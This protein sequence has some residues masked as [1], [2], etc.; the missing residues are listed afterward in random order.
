MVGLMSALEDELKQL[1]VSSLQLEDTTPE[2]IDSD[3][4]LFGADLGLDSIDALELAV[5][6][7]K[8]YGV[9]LQAEDEK[10]RAV[11]SSVRTLAA[12]VQENRKI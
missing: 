5:A 4:A 1:I 6:L 12:F 9:Q 2:A 8:K 3:A 11:F 7:S 10:S